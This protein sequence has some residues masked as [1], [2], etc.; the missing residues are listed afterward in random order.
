M[1]YQFK[2]PFTGLSVQFG[3]KLGILSA[4]KGIP[5]A[6]LVKLKTLF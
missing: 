1:A 3:M 6:L 2:S 5:L 4:N